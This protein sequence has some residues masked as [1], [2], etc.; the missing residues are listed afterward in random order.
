[1]EHPEHVMGALI[2]L[3]Y[4][5]WQPTELHERVA[6]LKQSGNVILILYRRYEN[7]NI[8]RII[9]TIIEGVVIQITLPRGTTQS[10]GSFKPSVHAAITSVQ[11]LSAQQYDA[12]TRLLFKL[13][14]PTD[15]HQ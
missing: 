12:L 7:N 8:Y 14:K 11:T 10:D 5:S 1:M 3:N 13:L 15:H 4:K 2:T 6:H 9:E